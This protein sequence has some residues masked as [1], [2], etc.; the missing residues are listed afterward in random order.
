MAGSPVESGAPEGE[1][2]PE[3]Q[4]RRLREQVTARR[5]HR[6]ARAE[7]ERPDALACLSRPVVPDFSRAV[8]RPRARAVSA[9]ATERT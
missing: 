7:G 4:D 2:E 8:R 9:W 3:N 1:A 6:V 5:P